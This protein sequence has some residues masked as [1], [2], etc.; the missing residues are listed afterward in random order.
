MSLDAQSFECLQRILSVLQ[1]SWNP[2]LGSHQWLVVAGNAGLLRILYV[3][4]MNSSKAALHASEL[5]AQ[6]SANG[7]G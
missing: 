1:L 4:K 3:E 5:S 6:L 7:A 2:N